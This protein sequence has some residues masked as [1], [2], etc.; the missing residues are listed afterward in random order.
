M[1]QYLKNEANLTITENGA[2][3]HISSGTDCMDLFFRAG[4][5]RGADPGE[6]ADA[7][8]HAYIED[9]VKTMKILFFVRDIR[10]G[11]GERRFFRIAVQT[12]AAIAPDSVRRNLPLFAEYGRYDDV[13][14]LLG[15]A[16]EPEAIALIRTQ[17]QADTAARGKGEPVSLLAK[18]LPS[19]NASA[20]ETRAAGRRIAKALGMNEKQYRKALAALRRYLDILENRLRTGD[21]TFSYEVQP[22]GA[23][24]KYRKAF[25]RNDGERYAAYLSAVEKHEAVMHADTLYPY[26]IIRAVDANWNGKPRHAISAEERRALQAAWTNLPQY[27]ASDENALAVVD[28]S[29][30]MYT[31]ACTPRPID[32]AMSL[33]IYF[34]EHNRGAFAN[35]F[36][37]FSEH[38]RLVELKGSD[39]VEK[40]LYCAGYNECA[41][42]NLEAVFDLI[43]RTALKNRLPQSE[44]PAKLYI[45]SDME[46]DY[47]A[48]GGNDLTMFAEMRR[49]YAEA[50]Y[51]L[52]E[53]IFWNVAS[54]HQNVPVS[55]SQT[56]AALVSGA[57]PVI[58]DMVMNGEATPELVMNRII[59]SAR[60]AKV[61]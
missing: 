7:V 30:S 22:S 34:A 44:L 50:G 28:G 53:I 32:A 8:C 58:F 48:R 47:C 4:G 36:I 3:T 29:G 60:Y 55:R 49:R 6:I 57:S 15:T 20:A 1:L 21:Y 17:F 25:I 42:T 56:G 33:G 18:W 27:G 14:A 11:L 45:I 37:T 54:R 10:G 41:N 40:T 26:D 2:L 38:P 59:E 61:S 13:C 46:F 5:M 23:M 39:I 9:P 35:H 43:L 19:V 52:P 24:L 16:C 51:R 12:V 31:E